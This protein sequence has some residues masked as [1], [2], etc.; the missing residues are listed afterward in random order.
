M[1][2]VPQRRGAHGSGRRSKTLTVHFYRSSRADE[3]LV[4]TKRVR[5]KA[6][7]FND[8]LMWH[9]RGKMAQNTP[10]PPSSQRRMT[11][12]RFRRTL[13]TL[14]FYVDVL[15]LRGFQR[16]VLYSLVTV[17]VVRFTMA[18]AMCGIW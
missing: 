6:A 7:A 9:F 10:P 8:E 14:V 17:W 18:A 12:F 4:G 11:T 2:L 1:S 3:C 13:G 5:T 15:V 16:S